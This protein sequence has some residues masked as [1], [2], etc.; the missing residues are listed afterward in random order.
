MIKYVTHIT[1]V[2]EM[3]LASYLLKN[4]GHSISHVVNEY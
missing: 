2:Y 1:M 3:E 4:K